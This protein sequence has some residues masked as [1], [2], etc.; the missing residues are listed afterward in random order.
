MFGFGPI[1]KL[2]S[3]NVYLKYLYLA[4]KVSEHDLC[5]KGVHVTSLYGFPIVPLFY[6]NSSE[7]FYF[8]F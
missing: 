7:M 3:A 4:G 6:V 5:V 1:D 8:N 2:S